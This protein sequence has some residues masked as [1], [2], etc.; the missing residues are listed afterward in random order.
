MKKALI[1][2]VS[3]FSISIIAAIYGIVHNQFTY[4][5]SDE[6]FTKFMFEKFGFVEYGQET[7]RLTASIIGVLSCWW[8]GLILGFIFTCVGLFN[9]TPSNMIK[10]IYSTVLV[11]FGIVILIGLIGFVY[12]FS[13]LSS[14]NSSCCFP[15]Q[16]D[17]VKSF[18][19]ISSMHTFSYIG[20]IVGAFVGLLY[21][22]NGIK[23]N[24][25]KSNNF[26]EK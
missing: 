26:S 14:L 1:F 21:Q 2:I 24:F 16:I 17:N 11:T 23:L 9:K 19:A 15:L 22:I 25:I 20:V 18:I 5:I 8:I 6:F 3:I 7:P 13:G 12:G 10:S 4:T